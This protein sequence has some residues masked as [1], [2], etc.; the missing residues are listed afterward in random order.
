M[1]SE[2][3]RNAY[4]VLG[5]LA[6]VG[7]VPLLKFLSTWLSKIPSLTVDLQS[8]SIQTTGLG[9]VLNPG[10]GEYAMKLLG[11][12]NLPFSMDFLPQWAVIA[13]GGALAMWLGAIVV[14]WFG[15]LRSGSKIKKTALVFLAGSTIAGAIISWS[16]S[17]PTVATIVPLIM[18]TLILSWIFVTIDNATK[19]N[20][21]P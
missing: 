20:L 2:K 4:L 18:S 15:G 21:V 11:K 13:L 16:I 9:N 1:I 8:V 3:Q 14:D 5:A 17:I 6:A 19:W 10:L 12:V 7:T